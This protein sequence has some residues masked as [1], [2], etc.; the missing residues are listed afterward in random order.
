VSFQ[1]GRINFTDHFI[2]PNYSANLLEIG[3]RV[4]G[5]SSE[6]TRMADVDLRGKLENYA[7]LEI[8]GKINPLRNDLYVDLK[9]DFKDMDL[10]PLTPYSGRYDWPWPCSRT[11]RGRSRST[12]L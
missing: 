5:L 12:C 7:P 9:V 10:S 4:S 2:K 1:G 3:G 11:G 6:E 8:T